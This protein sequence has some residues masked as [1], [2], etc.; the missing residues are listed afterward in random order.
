MRSTTADIVAPFVE[1]LF[2]LAYLIRLFS[3]LLFC[4]GPVSAR[5]TRLLSKLFDTI[6]TASNGRITIDQ[7]IR[8]FNPNT[9]LDVRNKK[10]APQVLVQQLGDA[11]H[12]F[13][14]DRTI[15]R[16]EFHVSRHGC[17]MMMLEWI[18]D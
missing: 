13:N 9:H 10:V 12:G 8:L 17:S 16:D 14:P 15:T 2:D 3:F 11:F 7:L 1:W 5:R 6:D 18:Y 4:Q